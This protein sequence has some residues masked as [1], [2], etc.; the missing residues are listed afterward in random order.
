MNGTDYP[1]AGHP[2][3]GVIPNFDNPESI[4]YRLIIVASVFP[5]VTGVFLGLRL[6]TAAFILRRWHI[7]DYL[8]I[9]AFMLAVG[10]SITKSILT[11]YGAGVHIWDVSKPMY[12]EF[13]KIGTIA[14]SFFYHSSTLFAKF[15][16]LSFY[17]RFSSANRAFRMVTY[18]VMLVAFGYTTPMALSFLFQCRPM[19]LA[20]DER[21]LGTGSCVDIQF[22]CYITGIMNAT[23]DFI[24]L[25]LP[26]WLLQPL[27]IPLARK[28][29][30]TFIL[31]TGGF[32][33]LISALRTANVTNNNTDTD[34]TYTF[35]PNLVWFLV[36]LYF[37]ILCA[38]LPCLKPFT[39]RYFPGF[40]IFSDSL[41]SRMSTSI[42]VVSAR[43]RNITTSLGFSAGASN[44]LQGREQD[45]PGHLRSRPSHSSIFSAGTE[46]GSSACVERG[47]SSE[48]S[49]TCKDFRV[50]AGKASGS[51]LREGGGGASLSEK[52][53]V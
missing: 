29:G 34:Y 47:S 20:W 19:A 48:G 38:C 16:I 5:V 17:L 14:G 11:N 44:H 46:K 3:P 8:I 13:G 23:T 30:V 21:L 31:M 50:V 25:L 24:I 39:K 43:A 9:V 45:G 26:I 42:N 49:S 52:A 1:G 2:P 10:D 18:F 33:C 51:T 36:E 41:E 35:V 6:Y 4:G 28:V 32:V 12:R 37:G 27:T 40:S 15:S 22:M 53:D 7:D